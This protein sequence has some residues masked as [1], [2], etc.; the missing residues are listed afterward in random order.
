LCIAAV[1]CGSQKTRI[2][3]RPI[4]EALHLVE[5]AG[6]VQFD[7]ERGPVRLNDTAAGGRWPADG[8]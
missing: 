5:T 2:A 4:F 6:V 8:G 1:F 7:G 3:S